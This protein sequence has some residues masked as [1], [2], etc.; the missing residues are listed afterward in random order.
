[1]QSQSETVLSVILSIIQM[2]ILGN[3]TGKVSFSNLILICALI[4]YLYLKT[5]INSKDFLPLLI[6][7][8]SA[9]FIIFINAVKLFILEITVGNK[10]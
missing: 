2:I 9:A 6:I 1:M 3:G 4:L 8:V 10:D 5:F 7:S